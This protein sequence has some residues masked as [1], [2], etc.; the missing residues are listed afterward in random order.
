VELARRS[1]VT[2]RKQELYILKYTV[3]Q[4]SH[5]S[6]G[7]ALGG[8]MFAALVY[9]RFLRNSEAFA[10][11][12]IAHE[13]PDWFA[14]YGDI[15]YQAFTSKVWWP[16][17]TVTVS[18]MLLSKLTQL[19]LGYMAYK[20]AVDVEKLPFPLAPVHAEGAI[21][22][23][24][25]SKDENKKGFRQYCFSVGIICGAVFGA[26][27]VGVPTLTNAFFGTPQRIIP[28][29]F[30]D[31]TTTFEPWLH[32]GTIGISL[33]LT[34]LFI[35]FVV[36]WRIV[37]G[38][39]ITALI[40][41]IFVNPHLQLAGYLPHWKPGKDAIATNVSANLDLYMSVGIGTAL[42]IAFVGILGLVRSVLKFKR[43]STESEG[44]DIRNF[45]RRDVARGDVPTWI[46]VTVWLF[47]ATGF[48]VLSN[49]LINFN[50]P[51]ENQ[52]HILW[53]IVFAF[54]WTPLNTYIN[55]RMIGI[56]GYGAGV[57]Y[58]AES[59][60]YISQYRYANIW[61]APMPLANYGNMAS[62]LRETQLTRTKFTSILKVE[63]LVFPLMMIAS[64]IFWSYINGLGPIPSDSYPYVQK[65]WPQAA[66]M[67]AVWASGMRE[68]DSLLSH[69]IKPMVIV[70]GFA[71]TSG[72]FGIFSVAGISTQY[73][74][75]AMGALNSYPHY[76]LMT[77]T[78]ACLG[79]FV[80]ARK[81]GR[82]KWT[83]YAP[84]LAVGFQAGMGLMGMLCIAIY[85]LYVAI[86]TGY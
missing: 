9:N 18:A 15:A 33:D 42:A 45:V 19:S 29:P 60:I 16:I 10:N 54:V 73:L 69:A 52:F 4:L 2:L 32:G 38:G 43:S 79:R 72:L 67:K 30:L 41:Q 21:A 23:A 57:P 76:V 66:Q 13:V 36:P 70:G 40:M 55:A 1:F 51:K 34:L 74:Y 48:V 77:F 75:G 47:S 63:L 27:Y 25:R 68:G 71:I 84:I 26:I 64:F 14:P 86:G 83:N 65:F 81:F 28:I 20:L 56:T 53:L 5:I 22:L 37:L 8:G 58:I 39:V 49:Y 62:F 61:F 80:F 17:I 24:E 82:E 46:A 44:V 59:A 85:F 11:F 3:S 78:G 6:G 31:L 12:G 35:G 7:L 50:V